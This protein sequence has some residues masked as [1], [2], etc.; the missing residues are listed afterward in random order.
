MINAQ[1]SSPMSVNPTPSVGASVP[2]SSVNTTTPVTPPSQPNKKMSRGMK[3]ALGLV[4][5]LVVSIGGGVSYYLTQR[6]QDIR[7]QADELKPSATPLV[8]AT[9]T[10]ATELAVCTKNAYLDPGPGRMTDL[11]ETKSFNSTQG[12]LFRIAVTRTSD[13]IIPIV[14][15]DDFTQFTR[16]GY[17]FVSAETNPGFTCQPDTNFNRENPGYYKCNWLQPEANQTLMLYIRLRPTVTFIQEPE[18]IEATNRVTV[19]PVELTPEGIE[20]DTG[21]RNTPRG[22]SSQC[23]VTVLIPGTTG[24]TPAPTLSCNTA[25]TA[26][27]PTITNASSVDPCTAAL[28]SGY[29]CSQVI[30]RPA[31]ENTPTHRCRLKLAPTEESC[32]VATATASPTPS[33]T[34]RATATP[35]PA[36]G[37]NQTCSNNADCSNPDHVCADVGS[38]QKACRLSSNVNSASC[39]SAISQTTQQ[40]TLPPELPQTGAT[41]IDTW[42]KAGLGVLSLGIMFLLFL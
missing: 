10:P 21:N 24:A 25:C 15:T 4:L 23:P 8:R 35:T 13:E 42:V 27:D 30:D 6:Q 26:P 33:P 16:A 34:A 19:M 18:K 9:P 40:P 22:T 17:E 41:D 36:I 11:V 37:C 1:S 39:T 12:I 2:P 7:Q 32:K 20:G 31:D 3:I 28:G 14:V 38:G 5:L 29:F